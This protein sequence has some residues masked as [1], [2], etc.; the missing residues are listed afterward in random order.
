MDDDKNLMNEENEE[1]K[2]SL[3][4]QQNKDPKRRGI[5]VGFA[6]ILIPY[7]VIFF[8]NDFNIGMGMVAGL[9]FAVIFT[10]VGGLLGAITKHVFKKPHLAI[11][12]IIGGL[13]T[14]LVLFIFSGG[15]G[16]L[17]NPLG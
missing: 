14:F 8:L 17:G 9:F 3:Y 4:E 1:M 11:G 15:C 12:F 7:V 10:V 13:A 5:L 2:E 6:I 16:L